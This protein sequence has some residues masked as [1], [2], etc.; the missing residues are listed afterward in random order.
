MTQAARADTIASFTLDSGARLVVEPIA[1]AQSAALAWLTPAGSADEPDDKLG[2]GAMLEELLLRGAA[3]K[4]SREI[5]DA[6]D[7]LG[8]SRDAR[9]ETFHLALSST[10][11][12]ARFPDVARLIAGSIRQPALAE[13]A[14]DPARQLALQSLKGLADEPQSRVMYA[15]REFHAPDPINRSGLGTETGLASITRDDLVAYWQRRARPEGS[16][17]AVAGAVE[18]NAAAGALNQL[19]SGWSGAAEPPAWSGA[20]A[21]GY[22]HIESSSEQTHIAVIHDAP[23][24]PSND[25]VLER[26]AV[27]VLSGGMSG[28][29]FT[30][31]REKRGLCYAVSAGYAAQ[32]DY[33]RVIAYSGTTPERA[34]DTLDV[35][36]AELRRINEKAGA[37]DQSEFDRARIGLKSRLVMSGESTTAR[38]NALAADVAKLGRP[39]SLTEI[40]DEI[41][42]V[43]LDQLND[44]LARRTLGA[45][46]VCTL[47]P[48]ELA[49]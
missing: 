16:I 3:G 22:H 8:A 19:L 46:T 42:A 14:V 12:G 30:E 7:L 31:V 38:A 47:G 13:D 34:Q 10:F 2:L 43:T 35:L 11:L 28:R 49:F 39:R 23:A 26:L 32:R 20:G 41:D 40:A 5:A 24:E 45:L 6:T 18:P 48:K 1:S 27:A 15:A 17:I 25:A 21:R 33:G 29:L 4:S 44:Y 9:L 37:V 36:V